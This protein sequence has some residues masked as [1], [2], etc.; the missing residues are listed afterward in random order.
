MLMCLIPFLLPGRPIILSAHVA[1]S[2]YQKQNKCCHTQQ[3]T[4]CAPLKGAATWRVIPVSMPTTT[5][6][7][8]PLMVTVTNNMTLVHWPFMGGLLH[9]VQR[10]G[11]RVGPQPAQAPPRCTKCNSPPMNGQCTNHY[12][13]IT[14]LFRCSAVVPTKG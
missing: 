1:F 10:E 2:D 11:D 7:V 6:N 5:D 4:S 12:C 3:T 14:V 8:N 9:L 13:C